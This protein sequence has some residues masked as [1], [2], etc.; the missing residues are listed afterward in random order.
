MILIVEMPAVKFRRSR[1]VMLVAFLILVSSVG[2]W[3]MYATSR[4]RSQL[5]EL[6]SDMDMFHR[7][8]HSHGEKSSLGSRVLEPQPHRSIV[9]RH[10]EDHDYSHLYRDQDRNSYQKKEAGNVHVDSKQQNGERGEA[11]LTDDDKYDY[12]DEAEEIDRVLKSKE[13]AAAAD[14]AAADA[15]AVRHHDTGR[16]DHHYDNELPANDDDD[17]F[18]DNG[19]DNLRKED[20]AQSSSENKEKVYGISHNDEIVMQQPQPSQVAQRKETV[21]NVD[22]GSVLF[23]NKKQHRD[24]A[25]IADA[26]AAAEQRKKEAGS[27]E[28]QALWKTGNALEEVNLDKTDA[29]RRKSEKDKIREQKE[30]TWRLQQLNDGAQASHVRLHNIAPV[31]RVYGSSVLNQAASQQLPQTT[32]RTSDF[33]DVVDNIDA[34]LSRRA[35]IQDS[36]SSTYFIVHSSRASRVNAALHPKLHALPDHVQPEAYIFTSSRSLVKNLLL[37][38]HITYSCRT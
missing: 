36:T 18:D 32:R 7:H 13:A 33:D 30:E 22:D 23:D 37:L 15:G 8:R 11:G 16:H 25:E 9:P 14:A 29:R 31:P 26:A 12:N 21:G 1:V 19:D 5:S 10:H 35:A 6:H 17:D 2:Y 38:L 4:S 20:D 28:Q 27:A 3:L 34:E 24:R